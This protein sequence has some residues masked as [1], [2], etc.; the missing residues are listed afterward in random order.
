ML[1]AL[2]KFWCHQD[3]EQIVLKHTRDMLKIISIN[4]IIML[5]LVLHELF[6]VKCCLLMFLNIS[7]CRRMDAEGKKEW[8]KK[9]LAIL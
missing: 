5:L 9:M 6:R 2:K 3:G 8:G 1:Y 7:T 4:N